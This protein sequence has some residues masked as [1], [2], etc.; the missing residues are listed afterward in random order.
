MRTELAPLKT[1]LCGV[2]LASPIVLAAGTCGYVDEI[3]VALD[4][5]RIGAVT[6]KSITPEPREG[7]TPMRVLDVKAGMINA[8]GLANMGIEA[9]MREKVPVIERTPTVVIGSIA[10][11]SVED[12]VTVASRF[13]TIDAMPIVEMNVS[14]PNCRDGRLATASPEILAEHVRAVRSV[15]VD[16][17]LFVKLPPRTDLLVPLAAAAGEAGAD[18]ITMV[19]TLEVLSIDIRTRRSVLG[20]PRKGMSGPAIHHL[21][22]RLVHDV[23]RGVTEEAGVPIIGLGGVLDWK[24]AAEMILA[25]ATAVGVGTGLFVD[26]ASPRR[27]SRGL[28][29]WMHS[30]GCDSLSQLVGAHEDT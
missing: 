23:Y 14:C 7:N 8:V 17:K 15:L 24:D 20:R 28:A 29:K 6:T 27:M 1:D 11:F 4:L 16:K 3:S 21:A 2:T 5:R 18:G 22:V 10:G 9:F 12:Y 25:G 26:P 13:Q 19:N 30:Q